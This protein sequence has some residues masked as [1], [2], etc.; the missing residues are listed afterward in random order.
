MEI[1]WCEALLLAA[2]WCVAAGVWVLI[3]TWFGLW[4]GM[5]LFVWLMTYAYDGY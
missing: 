3:Q 4:M 2:H 5:D 1:I